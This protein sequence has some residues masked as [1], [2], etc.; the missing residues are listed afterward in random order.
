MSEEGFRK[1]PNDPNTTVKRGWYRYTGSDGKVYTTT[2]WAD[3]NG[4]TAYG[5]HLPKPPPVPPAIQE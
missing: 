4:Y 1:D 5:D 2:Y 3:E